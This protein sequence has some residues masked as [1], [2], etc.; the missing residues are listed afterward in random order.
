MVEIRVPTD[1]GGRRKKDPVGEERVRNSVDFQV[2]QRGSDVRGAV[3]TVASVWVVV[4]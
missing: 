4:P 2:S 1:D 3:K